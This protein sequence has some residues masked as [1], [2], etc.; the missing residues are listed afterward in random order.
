MLKELTKFSLQHRTL[1][2][3]VVLSIW[4]F[5][6]IAGMYKYIGSI[7]RNNNSL[8]TIHGFG[9]QKTKDYFMDDEEYMSS[10]IP[11]RLINQSECTHPKMLIAGDEGGSLEGWTL[12]GV[13]LLVRHGDRGPM[14]H[15]RGISGVD[16]GYENDPALN[17]MENKLRYVGS[18][19]LH[20]KLSIKI[21]TLEGENV[22]YSYENLIAHPLLKFSGMHTEKVPALKV[23]IQIF[24]N[25]VPVGLAVCTSHKQF[26]TR[27]SWNEWVS[28]PLRFAD[29]SRTAMLSF[30]IFDCAGGREQATVVGRT[31]ISF[32]S[33]NGLFRQGL[34]DLKVWP[35]MKSTEFRTSIP[36]HSFIAGVSQM[37]RL[38]RLAKEHRNGEMN[39][40]D[41]LDRLTFRELEV[42]NE[43]EK[44]NSQF[45][46]L[47]VEF[48]Q[49]FID[50]KQYSIM[51]LEMNVQSVV[52]YVPKPKIV[53]VPDY[54]IYQE[55][56][57]ERKH[58]RL[59]RSARAGTSDRDVKP[60]AIARDT[61]NSIV[62]RYSPTN[63]LNSEEQD[64]I[65]KYRFYL[66][67]HKKALTKFLK[68]VNW[69]TA[70]EVRQALTLLE[71][72]APMDVE[73]ALEL[74]N[75]TF[76][77]P[78]VRWY[79]ITRLNEASDE[80]LL[81]YLLQ[82]VQA[83]KYEAVDDA[84]PI[85]E[86]SVSGLKPIFQTFET[87]SDTNSYEEQS[88]ENQGIQKSKR[89]IS[90][91]AAFLIKRAC[92][93][94]ILANYLYW[95]LT[96]ECED[97][98]SSKKDVTIQEMY[99][100]VL[101]DFLSILYNGTPDMKI[102]HNQLKEQQHFVD[103]LVTLVKIVAKESGNRKRK[104]EKFQQFLIESSSSSSAKMNFNQFGP[105]ILPLDP[106][107][108][109]VGIVP[110]K[111]SLFKSALMPSK[112]T[113]RTTTGKEY[114]A[115]FKHGDDLR[116]DQLILQMIT[117]MDK[118]LQKENLDLKLT[119]Y[120]VLATSSRHGFMQ[121]IDSV[122]VADVLNSEGSIH[123]YFRK[124][125]PYET[126]PFGIMPEIM[127]TYIKSCAGY[128]VITYLLGIGD[129]HLD[130]LLL[131]TSGKLFHIDFGYIL[132]RDPKPMPPPMKL[133]KEMVD[134]MGG[135]SSEYYH[136]FRKLCYTAFLHLRR[137]A[138][139]MLN[140]F[141]LMVD[142]SVPDIALEPDKS[143]KKVEDNLRLDL[144]DEEA[145]QHLQNLLDISITAVMPALVEQ[146]H[147]L[148]QYWRK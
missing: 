146:I 6:L 7:E 49:L 91:L 24:D 23:K 40:V 52:A 96:I 145:V 67:S 133:S 93:N 92:K 77:H 112:I 43:M 38:S 17:S 126:G 142:A 42:I 78:S 95:Y 106:N 115:I 59:S 129:R 51:H 122:T 27:W 105:I 22:G 137:H 46:Y 103:R 98:K 50:E 81:L 74:L 69:E 11:K 64:I 44:R 47:M 13:L 14:A 100:S 37:Q 118:L 89:N 76:R 101:R 36:S 53:V 132:G 73:D 25:N 86:E 111:V 141:G 128:C 34:Y 12:Q 119:P 57:V 5:L 16:C 28:L 61:L 41:W 121:Y 84:N 72:W 79:A 114:D 63:P 75:S 131:T 102:M 3:Y 29:I 139:V 60:N 33:S 65:W 54:E 124:F 39:K 66:S 135:I 123:N 117:L 99:L 143:V 108:Q 82:L 94:S 134:A 85:H 83:L 88:I 147:K 10:L 87:S 144:S 140:L 148:A 26:T 32:F 80:Y 55:N 90:N 136:A 62:Y 56:L 107:I 70:T 18:T 71:C 97:E 113:F 68:C 127:D 4:I 48:P 58:H 120:R 20:E 35:Q 15:V 30:T 116:Q 104:T 8:L 45:L 2:C 1:Y 31:S 125:N 110:E 9:Y 19:S 138:N 21:G 130:N 109:I